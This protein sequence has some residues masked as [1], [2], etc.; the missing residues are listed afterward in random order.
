M[1]SEFIRAG[2]METAAAGNTPTEPDWKCDIKLSITKKP[3]AEF[4]HRM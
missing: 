3:S 1:N 4:A 2:L